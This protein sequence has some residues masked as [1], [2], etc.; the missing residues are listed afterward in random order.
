ML[1]KLKKDL[2]E[3]ANK[4]KAIILQRFFKTGKGE[5]GEGDVFLGVIVPEQRKISKKYDLSLKQIQEL[6]NSKIHE[7]RLVALLI[8]IDKY[9][10]SKE[11][12][13]IIDFY[14]SNLRRGNI[15]NWDLVDLSCYK[16]LGDYLIDKDRKI[17]YDLTKGNLWE[18]RV[19]VISCFCFIRKNDF[20]DILKISEI[21]LNDEHQL[22]H[23]AVGWMLREVGKR[24]KKILIDFLDK[25]YTKMP[26]IMFRYSVERL[27][28]DLIKKYSKNKK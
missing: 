5:Y 8:L 9:K 1:N 24:D 17:L 19:A 27:E 2:R 22:I 4:E 21:L 6:L 14:K 18:R 23:K 20:T 16:I 10:N 15:N 7:E 28:E 12:E 26:R 25:N 13:K 11:K 3:K